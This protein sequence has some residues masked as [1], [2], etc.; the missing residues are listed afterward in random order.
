M[1][2]LFKWLFSTKSKSKKF[3]YELFLILYLLIILA[4]AI[5]VS[6]T[7]N[8][9][10]LVDRI[11]GNFVLI[12]WILFFI[13]CII[14]IDDIVDYNAKNKIIKGEKPLNFTPILYSIYDIEK[15][16][17][18]AITPDTIYVKSVIKNNITIISVTF[19][20][21]GRNGP[22][23]NKQIWINDKEIMDLKDIQQEIKNTCEIYNDCI[24]LLAITEYNN[25]KNFTKIIN[26]KS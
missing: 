24:Y 14:R 10:N 3:K 21:V 22:F 20:V 1:K 15:W 18:N 16:L 2:R 8:L 17:T 7:A 4:I 19:E 6:N 13:P 12:N 5:L 23:F 9:D 25:P 26:E 11:I